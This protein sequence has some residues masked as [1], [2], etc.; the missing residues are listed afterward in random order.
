MTKQLLFTLEKETK[1]ALR[2]N[3]VDKDGKAIEHPDFAIGT[4]YLRKSAFPAPFPQA[5][6]VTVETK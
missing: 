1:G 5:I 2:Y 4:L 6:A 3:E